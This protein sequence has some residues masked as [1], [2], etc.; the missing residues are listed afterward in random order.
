[1]AGETR[2]RNTLRPS[3]LPIFDMTKRS[4]DI[5][6]ILESFLRENFS[7]KYEEGELKTLI[8]EATDIIREKAGDQGENKTGSPAKES[9]KRTGDIED[10]LKRSLEM[11]NEDDGE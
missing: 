4:L 7:E 6:S 11:G 3:G 9:Q 8:R 2:R 5:Y 1:M 10:Q